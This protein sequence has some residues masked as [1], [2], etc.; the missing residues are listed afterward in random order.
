MSFYPSIDLD[1]RGLLLTII[2]DMLGLFSPAIVFG[3]RAKKNA[4]RPALLFFLRLAL[5]SWRRFEQ[6]HFRSA[7]NRQVI[8]MHYAAHMS[9][10]SW[11]TLTTNSSSTAAYR[12]EQPVYA[13]YLPSQRLSSIIYPYE[14]VPS[15]SPRS[16]RSTVRQCAEKNQS[17]LRSSSRLGLLCKKEET[18]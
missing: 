4:S 1:G 6:L 18:K 12:Y 13:D 5:F 2:I 15:T 17:S 14:F 10:P 7:V 8:P 11:N 3:E 16:Y 9:F